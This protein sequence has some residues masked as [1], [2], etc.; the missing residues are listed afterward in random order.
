MLDIVLECTNRWL[1]VSCTLDFGKQ[2]LFRSQRPQFWL[3][4][5]FEKTK[6]NAA[7]LAVEP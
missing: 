2:S 6:Q 1:L 7:C 4:K 5:A 3:A